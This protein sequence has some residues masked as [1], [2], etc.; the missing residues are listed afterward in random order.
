MTNDLRRRTG[1][2]LPLSAIV[3]ST[4]WGIGE[5]PDLVPMGAWLA[6]AGCDQLMLLP[7][8]TM[9]PG[10]SSPYSAC[11][12]MAIDPIY[13]SLPAVE[14]FQRAGGVA[15][16]A[17]E[18]RDLLVH[19]GQSQTVLFQSVRQLKESALA[20]AFECFV[21]DE[22][23][24]RTLRAAALAAFIARE[25]WWLDDYALFQACA[26]EWPDGSWQAWPA[27]VARREP[28]ALREVRRHLG[29]RILF[30]QYVQW[31]ADEQWSRARGTLQSQAVA[32]FGDLPFVVDGH[33]ADVWARQ[34]EFLIDVS[35]GVPPDAFSATGQDWGLPMYRWDVIHR[36]GFTW[37]RHRARRMAAL[38]DGFRVDHL[39]GFYRTYGKAPDG[40]HFF[41][42]P[43]EPTQL[44]QGE[45]VMAVFR[46]TGADVV[47]EDLG[48][49]PPFVRESITR[50]GVGGYK[51]LRW[52]RMWDAPGRPF[53]APA[54]YPPCSVAT[55]GTHDTE[56]MPV[57]WD[58]ASME[59]RMALV[60][61]LHRAGVGQW[62]ANAPWTDSLRDGLLRLM[63]TRA[64]SHLFFPIQDVFGWRD[65]INT[66][67]TVGDHNWTWRLP[68]LIDQ[69]FQANVPCER[70]AF[71]RF[72]RT[73][74]QLY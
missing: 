58:E 5:I 3:S 51:V 33:S 9:P 45:Q 1:V 37:L 61:V 41:L 31:A 71:L 55:T 18:L 7:V 30:E 2:S 54:D 23:N 68:V 43:D 20:L 74:S 32:L 38:Y 8:G 15:E 70:A 24:H 59:D 19:V 25:R 21:R 34:D 73:D 52:E 49:V 46:E 39:V 28:A 29:H 42:P 36:S 22:W 16:L 63:G 69:W 40:T 67:A 64:S 65:R 27:D 60:E 11:S 44:W 48:T 4:S 57:W 50:M 14:D 13:V 66:P 47:A 12:A 17:P 72:L 6:S 53:V 35:V 56:P 26:S 10:Q 62:D